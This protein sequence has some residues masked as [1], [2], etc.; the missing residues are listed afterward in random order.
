MKLSSAEGDKM[1]NAKAALA[2]MLFLA[3]ANMAADSDRINI[4]LLQVSVNEAEPVNL[5]IAEGHEAQL[6]SPDGRA[7]DLTIQSR[8]MNG[9]EFTSVAIRDF[10]E[11]RGSESVQLPNL[12][13]EG[14]T[15]ASISSSKAESGPEFSVLIADIKPLDPIEFSDWQKARSSGR[16]QRQ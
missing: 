13:I 14:L 3:S 4:Y 11:G 9:R 2:A 8:A 7:F 1:R 10:P 16:P 5:E 6:T 12:M 15:E